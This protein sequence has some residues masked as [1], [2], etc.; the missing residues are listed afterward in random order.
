MDESILRQVN[1]KIAELQNIMSQKIGKGGDIQNKTL[2]GEEKNHPIITASNISEG[3]DK[4]GGNKE[5]ENKQISRGGEIVQDG[6]IVNPAILASMAGGSGEVPGT[7]FMALA[8]SLDPHNE[9]VP[10]VITAAE[11]VDAPETNKEI[12]QELKSMPSTKEHGEA[13]KV[14]EKQISVKSAA[15]NAIAEVVARAK[16]MKLAVDE[17]SE[18]LNDKQ[19]TQP[20]ENKESIIARIR[21]RILQRKAKVEGHPID[22]VKGGE[23]A[24]KTPEESVKSIKGEAK[25][26]PLESMP[27]GKT[28]YPA[29]K[30]N[31]IRDKEA[32]DAISK[33]DKDM[34]A[35]E[36]EWNKDRPVTHKKA[37]LAGKLASLEVFAESDATW[38]KENNFPIKIKYPVEKSPD[39]DFEGA[40]KATEKAIKS[41]HA[42]RA[43]DTG[44]KSPLKT[45]L[46]SDERKT[47]TSAKLS[48]EAQEFISNK[49]SVLKGEGKDDAQA[50]AIAYSMA[51]EK[52]FDVPEKKACIDKEQAKKQ[53]AAYKEALKAIK[54]DSDEDIRRLQ[55][56]EANVASLEKEMEKLSTVSEERTFESIIRKGNELYAGLKVVLADI[57][58]A[59]TPFLVEAEEV[60]KE[61]EEEEKVEPK[62][63]DKGGEKADKKDDKGPKGKGK[64]KEVKDVSKETLDLL[65]S[66]RDTVTE[67]SESIDEHLEGVEKKTGIP[68]MKPPM[69][70]EKEI[71]GLPGE[72]GMPEGL[73]EPG[74]GMGGEEMPLPPMEKQMSWVGMMPRTAEEEEQLVEEVKKDPSLQPEQKW[75]E[76]KKLRKTTGWKAIFTKL[77]A[78]CPAA[79]KEDEKKEEKEEKKEAAVDK[80]NSFWSVYRGDELVLRATVEDLYKDKAEEAFGWASSQEYGQ[81]LLSAVLNDG[82]VVTGEKL[83][84]GSMIKISAK[85][86]KGEDPKAYY[87]KIFPASYVSELFKDLRKKSELQISQLQTKV[88]ELEKQTVALTK[89][90]TELQENQILHAKAEKS[91]QLI[92]VAVEKGLVDQKDFDSVVDGVMMMDDNAYETFA[93]TIVKAPTVKKA[94]TIDE[95]INMVK[96]ASRGGQGSSV[97]LDTPIQIMGSGTVSPLSEMKEKLETMWKKPPVQQ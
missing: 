30:G 3:I 33:G 85:K 31:D 70:P 48:S 91:L 76:I 62:S 42:E 55:V 43:K 46:W 22:P 60:K 26:R 1:Q 36:K 29:D 8:K 24:A 34:S 72:M 95:K 47:V 78:E 2:V 84:I 39:Q 68:P 49:I 65:E 58:S 27:E 57:S 63:D 87:R 19:V 71:P 52:G 12:N 56:I 79:K 66:I 41:E 45:T 61:A 44:V 23:D 50:S 75:N 92:R 51:R 82:L 11:K 35:A 94:T 32:K 38:R 14:V 21:E 69:G 86:G 97:T 88:G 10:A 73:K 83:G 20:A 13:E 80:K 93:S 16:Q 96:N 64:K 54:G 7:D 5:M 25:D 90:N 37:A 81:K 40:A 9:S 53:I 4:E 17:M 15:E 77:A 74:M 89:E 18:V 67:I 59:L 28:R 6:K